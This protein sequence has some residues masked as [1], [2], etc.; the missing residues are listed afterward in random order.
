[1]I[2]AS[3]TKLYAQFK[4]ASYAPGAVIE[5]QK[6]AEAVDYGRKHNCASFQTYEV[7]TVDLNGEII[8]GGPQNL[9]GTYHLNAGAL[10]TA[11]EVAARYETEVS[12]LE[13]LVQQAQADLKKTPYKIRP[14]RYRD[15]DA[16]HRAQGRLAINEIS[17]RGIAA[18]RDYFNT[19]AS[20]TLF[21]EV[22]GKYHKVRKTDVVFDRAGQQ[23]YPQP[24]APETSTTAADRQ[25]KPQ[26][27]APVRK[28]NIKQG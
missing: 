27:E 5:I 19:L 24:G 25:Q 10:M 23:I 18:L 6:V 14:A 11:A 8:K 4:T 12:K 15:N 13:P 21:F 16:Y 17:L 1:M 7:T 3:E 26:A 28:L 2:A 22:R 9:S 20:D